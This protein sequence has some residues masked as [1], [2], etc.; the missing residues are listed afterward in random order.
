[1]RRVDVRTPL[2]GIPSA[3][4]RAS[5][6]QYPL[7]ESGRPEQNH[8]MEPQES[9]PRQVERMRVLN[10]RGELVELPDEQLQQANRHSDY[11][12]PVY[13]RGPSIHQLRRQEF[14]EWEPRSIHR[15]HIDDGHPGSVLVPEPRPRH[16]YRN[17]HNRPAA[18]IRT[19]SDIEG[20]QPRYRER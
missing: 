18:P 1:M 11:R 6:M 14:D 10:A 9:Q 7:Q 8:S 20:G 16:D 13:V 5:T 2:F 4:T 15:E 19:Q 12:P 3:P 17:L